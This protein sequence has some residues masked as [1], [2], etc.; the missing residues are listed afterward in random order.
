MQVRK[1]RDAEKYADKKN[2]KKNERITKQDKN[3]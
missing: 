3:E 2:E 1:N